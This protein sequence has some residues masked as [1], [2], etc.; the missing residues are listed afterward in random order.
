MIGFR[1]IA[2]ETK[3]NHEIMGGKYM[4]IML[5]LISFSEMRVFPQVSLFKTQQNKSKKK[6]RLGRVPCAKNRGNPFTKWIF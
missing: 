4:H 5:V 6:K 3:E 2:K 1:S